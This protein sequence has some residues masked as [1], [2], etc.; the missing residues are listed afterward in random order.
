M[1]PK[2]IQPF[3]LNLSPRPHHTLH[4]RLLQRI[5]PTS[6]IRQS[7]ILNRSNIPFCFVETPFNAFSILFRVVIV[8][9]IEGR[10]CRS[11]DCVLLDVAVGS[12]QTRHAGSQNKRVKHIYF[13]ERMKSNE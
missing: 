3:K 5:K 8:L 1:I 7:D 13:Y 4:I 12:D 2:P 9:R 11:V 6:D 10:V